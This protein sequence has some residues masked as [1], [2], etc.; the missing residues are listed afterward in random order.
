MVVTLLTALDQ[1]PNLLVFG[2]NKM[3]LLTYLLTYKLP[4]S[5]VYGEIKQDSKGKY[6]TTGVERTGCMFCMFGCHL[7]KEPNRFQKMAITHPKQY[8]Y[9]INQLGLG[10][11]LDYIGVDY[12]PKNKQLTIDTI[13]D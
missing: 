11:V 8:D 7:E 12:K 10:E 5:S 2:L 6:Y 9:C 4:I 3:Y 13:E 1:L